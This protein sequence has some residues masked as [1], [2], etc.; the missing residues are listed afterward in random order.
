MKDSYSIRV[1][2]SKI[3]VLDTVQSFDR[4]KF[5]YI[6]RINV[7]DGYRRR[8]FGAGLLAMVLEDADYEGVT[9]LL[10]IHPSG[11]MGHADLERWY[12]DNGFHPHEDDEYGTVYLRAPYGFNQWKTLRHGA[13]TRPEAATPQPAPGPAPDTTV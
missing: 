7:P 3:A 13:N 9:L 10:E 11:D 2:N 12:G 6:S 4:E 8:G 5:Y 1:S